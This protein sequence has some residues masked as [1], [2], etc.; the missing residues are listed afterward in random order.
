[1]NNLTINIITI[2][3]EL[4]LVVIFFFLLNWCFDKLY[5]QIIKIPLLQK[6]NN[7]PSVIRRNFRVG[8]FFFSGILS[9]AIIGINGYLAYRGENVRDYS[10]QLISQIPTKFW[11]N[12]GLRVIKSLGAILAISIALR[13]FNLLLDKVSI[14]AQNFDQFTDND[15]SIATFFNTLKKNI[16][17]ASWIGVAILCAQFLILPPVITKYLYILL[18]IYL[19]ISIGLLVFKVV[20]VIIDSLDALSVKY[21]SPDNL[22]RFYDKFRHLIPL[23]KRCLEYIIYVFM[24]TLVAQQL[25][26]ISNLASWGVVGIKLI[27]IFLLSR[28]LIS[29]ASLIVEELLIKSQNLTE[30]QQQ[31]RETIAPLVKSIVKYFIYFGVGVLMLETIGMNPGPILAGAGILGLAVGLG[32]QNLIND[33]VS[34]FFILFENYYLVGDY[35]ETDKASGYVEAIELR[36]TRIR[37][38]LGQVY[39]VRNGDIASVTNFSKDFIY[40]YVEV[41]VDYDSNLNRVQEIIET[42]G[43]QLKEQNNDILEPTKVDGIKEFGDIRLSIFTITK[44]KPGRHVQVKRTLR[45]LLKEAFDRE[46]IYIPI[47]ETTDKPDWVIQSSSRDDNIAEK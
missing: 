24:A 14:Y 28:I 42:V 8:L 12:L 40:A 33:I 9:L 26:F 15:Q 10:L 29:I 34:G 3:A 44:V 25:D 38:Y 5:R 30:A 13:M 11:T 43:C 41:G 45:K 4:I 47:G 19:I 46:G 23:L 32:A 1:M 39:I 22:L 6:I 36:T 27:S 37:H 21:S 16:N 7:N 17:S 20:A 31:R 18:W 2:A 35:I